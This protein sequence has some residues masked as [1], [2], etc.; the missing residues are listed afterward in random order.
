MTAEHVYIVFKP[1]C[2][3]NAGDV[4]RHL[5]AIEAIIRKAGGD[6]FSLHPHDSAAFRFILGGDATQTEAEAI[7]QAL[8]LLRDDDGRPLLDA[9]QTPLLQT[10]ENRRNPAYSALSR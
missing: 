6:D 5:P 7:V 9:E 1:A 2:D 3:K 8:N 10:R 4:S